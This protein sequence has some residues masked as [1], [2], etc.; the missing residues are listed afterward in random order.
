[1]DTILD[2]SLL[3]QVISRA[4]RMGCQQSVLVDQL[5]MKGT[6][7]ECIYRCGGYE[8]DQNLHQ[9]HDKNQNNT[10]EGIVT[11]DDGQEL[12]TETHSSQDLHAITER[13]R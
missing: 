8:I 1:M 13:D 3:Q 5:I 2:N 10:M 9:N 12:I 4:Y 11:G 6:I 7:E